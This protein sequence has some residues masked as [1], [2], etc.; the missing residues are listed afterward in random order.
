MTGA[1]GLRKAARDLRR[2][3]RTV[4]TREVR[5]ALK[6]TVDDRLPPLLRASAVAHMPSGYGKVLAGSMRVKTTVKL[7]T[8]NPA[9]TVTI[10]G[11]GFGP[12]H[13]DVT[14]IDRGVLRHPVFGRTR[15]T[16]LGSVVS[17]WSVTRVVPGFADRAVQ[18]IRAPLVS[19]V[20][21]QLSRV[22]DRFNAGGSG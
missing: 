19:A 2:L 1:D 12:E 9:V 20:D 21:K 13:R 3:Q 14:T 18:A 5:G 6:S 15:R 16:T 11:D 8:G 4:I 7:S 10:W 22:A 17:P